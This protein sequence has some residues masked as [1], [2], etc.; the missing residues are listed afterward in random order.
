[1]SIIAN[2]IIINGQV[3]DIIKEKE[4]FNETK[5]TTYN[6]IKNENVFLTLVHKEDLE[7]ESE[8]LKAMLNKDE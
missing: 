4:I 8:Y 2:N 5:S 7:I 6:N 3:V 1:M